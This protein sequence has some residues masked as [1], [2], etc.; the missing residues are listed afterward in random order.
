MAAAARECVI[1]CSIERCLQ[2]PPI[3]CGDA[4]IIEAGQVELIGANLLVVAAEAADG[5]TQRAVDVAAGKLTRPG[6]WAPLYMIED[7]TMPKLA[8]VDAIAAGTKV[9]F[10]ADD[11]CLVTALSQVDAAG[12]CYACGVTLELSKDTA[13]TVRIA[14]DGRVTVAEAGTG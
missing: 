13:D 7:C 14:F 2:G 3:V 8:G 9:W 6:L 4:D 10:S 5:A 12:E 11:N 1:N